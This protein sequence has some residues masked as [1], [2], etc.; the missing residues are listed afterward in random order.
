MSLLKSKPVNVFSL[1][2]F[3]VISECFNSFARLNMQIINE[4]HCNLNVF[5]RPTRNRLIN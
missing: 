4:D 5:Y 1:E 3:G 2:N